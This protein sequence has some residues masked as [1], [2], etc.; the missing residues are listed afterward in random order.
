MSI[1]DEPFKAELTDEFSDGLDVSEDLNSLASTRF[2][3][4]RQDYCGV[5]LNPSGL[6]SAVNL[7]ADKLKQRFVNGLSLNSPAILAL[8]R[9]IVLSPLTSPY[10][11]VAE[12]IIN[13]LT[14]AINQD[15][16]GFGL[17][18][19]SLIQQ[20]Y[21]NADYAYTVTLDERIQ[22]NM[23]IDYAYVNAYADADSR[24][25]TG[26]LQGGGGKYCVP[27]TKLGNAYGGGIDI[28]VPANP[29]LQI[30]YRDI[31]S[32]I[33]TAYGLYQT[34]N[35]NLEINVDIKGRWYL[36]ITYDKALSESGIT[37]EPHAAISLYLMSWTEVN[38]LDVAGKTQIA[39]SLY[40]EEVGYWVYRYY[41]DT[42]SFTKTVEN[43]NGNYYYLYS[44]TPTGF[45]LD[46]SQHG[47]SIVDY[48]I[49]EESETDKRIDVY[50]AFLKQGLEKGQPCVSL[51]SAL[52]QCLN[53]MAGAELI[54]DLDLDKINKLI[55]FTCVLTNPVNFKLNAV[56]TYTL[57]LTIGDLLKTIDNIYC[58]GIEESEINTLRVA[59]RDKIR[60]R[61][62]HDEVI[63]Y[64]D[65]QVEVDSDYIFKT[66]K[67]GC[68]KGVSS[69]K[70][71]RLEVHGLIE[72]AIAGIGD[73]GKA[74]D[75]SMPYF[76][77]PTGIETYLKEASDDE[78]ASNEKDSAVFLYACREDNPTVDAKYSLYKAAVDKLDSI[79]VTI[80]N[81]PIT[82]ARCLLRHANYLSGTLSIFRDN[83]SYALTKSQDITYVQ[84]GSQLDFEKTYIYENKDVFD[85]TGAKPFLLPMK[86]SFKADE[87]FH[88]KLK[89]TNRNNPI[90][91]RTNI[92]PKKMQA[93]QMYEDKP[94]EE[95]SSLLV[96][97]HT[98]ID[99]AFCENEQSEISG[100]LATDNVE[101]QNS[102]YLTNYCLPNL[103]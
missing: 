72:Y 97:S 74:Y 16:V 2:G 26:A 17:K 7:T 53:I 54:T 3:L 79:A 20:I 29:T 50:C 45:A 103:I 68:D 49:N 30:E 60:R 71:G 100:T 28:N 14:L 46:D 67:A 41:F 13:D 80:Y 63:D 15:T 94:F 92:L 77:N 52:A 51:F 38:G 85:L 88:D 102:F 32:T 44:L 43:G 93:G 33:K 24:F 55:G 11:T 34:S 12:L 65:A 21:D 66:I 64:A 101:E 4:E 57:K 5:V 10:Q 76:C 83:L 87:Y 58:I 96:I 23:R 37:A 70:D 86:V 90:G 98:G 62:N 84:G 18:E 39:T 61:F 31:S 40:K 81:L 36:D 42:T 35:A 95:Y 99:Y 6:K 82:P 69:D 48:H 73:K 75:I 56:T 1:Y 9:S 78:T 8:K 19:K 25:A 89:L 22:D 27:L 91:I 47:I 59:D